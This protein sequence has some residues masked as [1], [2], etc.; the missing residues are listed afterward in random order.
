MV[1]RALQLGGLA[2]AAMVLSGCQGVS[3]GGTAARVRVIVASPNA[4]GVDVYAAGEPVAYNLTF[5]N[6][7]TYVAVGAG[8]HPVSAMTT[9]TRQALTAGTG[10][11]SGAGHYTVLLGDTSANLQQTILRDQS[12]AAPAGQVALRFLH[13]A[14]GVG[15]VDVFLVPAAASVKEV[16]P[17]LVGLGFGGSSGY[18]RVPAGAYR[19]LLYPA[20]AAG[21]MPLQ[22]GPLTTYPAGAARTV[23]LLDQRLAGSPAQVVMASDFEPGS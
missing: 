10:T 2:V 19:M 17:L 22:T 4:P 8:T 5:G 11:L 18:V 12:T 3:S 16:T 14:T 23:V 21:G 20:G 15:P 6:V 9:G 13:E 1:A 7:T